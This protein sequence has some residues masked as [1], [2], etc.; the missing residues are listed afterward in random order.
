MAEI[1]Q[2]L[3]ALKLGGLAKDWRTFEFQ[4]DTEKY[5]TELHEREVNRINR[6]VKTAG[7]N[8]IKTLDD[9]VWRN[10]IELP[11]GL[12]REYME[13]LGFI[14]ARENLI[15]MGAVGNR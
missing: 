3:R 4:G 12:T 6:L 2:M 5:L 10:D 13:N 9:F 8:V 1:E 11:N 15:F 7:F 14:K